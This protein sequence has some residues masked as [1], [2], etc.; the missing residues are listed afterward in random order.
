MRCWRVSMGSIQGFASRLALGASKILGVTL[1]VGLIG[2]AMVRMGPGFDIDEREWDA[3][4]SADSREAIRA[5]R[6]ADGNIGLFCL[7]Y[8]EG[9]LKGDLGLSRSYNQPVSQLIA[10][11]LPVTLG[12]LA[13]G[14]FG[15]ATMGLFLSLATLLWPARASDLFSAGFAGVFLSIPPAVVALL[16]LGGGQDGRWA[17]ALVVFPY[18]YRYS[19]NVLAAAYRSQHVLAALAK[20]LGKWAVLTRHVMLPV[21]PQLASIVSMSITVAFGASIP[22]EVI[23][24]LPGIGQLACQAALGRDLPLLVAITMLIAAITLMVNGCADMLVGEQARK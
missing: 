21:A 24:D 20:G 14:V 16:F 5:Q 12:S 6:L 11:R 4:L 22:I 17:I 23:C 10:E 13:Y 8:V 18:V 7:H 1:L 9:I 15:G 19:K 3:R 2:A